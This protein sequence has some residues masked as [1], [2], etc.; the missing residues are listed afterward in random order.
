KTAG[1]SANL[2]PS[3][4]VLLTNQEVRE[5]NSLVLHC[6][7]NK[8]AP[9]VEW[10]KGGEILRNGDKYQMRKKDLQVEM[11]I[12]D[13]TVEDSGDYTCLCG[14]QRTAAR[15]DVIGEFIYLIISF[16]S[17]FR[18]INYFKQKCTFNLLFFYLSPKTWE[19][20]NLL[21]NRHSHSIT[22]TS[23]GYQSTCNN[24]GCLIL[25]V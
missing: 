24:W 10:R 11:K 20:L 23:E 22:C 18:L 9:S 25:S 16:S 12:S 1:R 2:P 19:R 8:P 3:F 7:L 5:G 15:I 21:S 14:E 4:K 6:E 13:L 17:V